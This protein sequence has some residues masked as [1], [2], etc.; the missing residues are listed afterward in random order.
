MAEVIRVITD[1]GVGVGALLSRQTNVPQSIT[2]STRSRADLPELARD[3]AAAR[4]SYK[5]AARRATSLPE[6]RYLQARAVRLTD[7]VGTGN[8][9]N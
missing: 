7:A 1:R 6:Q 3:P 4:E 9:R 8:G 5:A 2:A